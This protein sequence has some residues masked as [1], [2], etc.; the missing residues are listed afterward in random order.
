[1]IADIV[2]MLPNRTVSL[3]HARGAVTVTVEGAMPG[4]VAHR[5]T[6]CI[7]VHRADAPDLGWEAVT[8]EVPLEPVDGLTWRSTLNAPGERNARL[9]VREYDLLPD[10]SERQETQRPDCYR[11]LT[12]VTRWKHQRAPCTRTPPIVQGRRR[13]HGPCIHDG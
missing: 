3:V 10:H 4:K 9:V 13:W 11:K 8:P 6:A 2:Q 1:M 7:E 5:V 12:T